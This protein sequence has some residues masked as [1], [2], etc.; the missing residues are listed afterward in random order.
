MLP[1]RLEVSGTISTAMAANVASTMWTMKVRCSGAG[2]YWASTP[3]STGPAPR[4]PI[5]ATVA[6]AGARS[7]QLGGAASM[8]AAVPV[9]VNSPADKPDS[10]R[11]TSSTGTESAPRNTA[12]LAS[13]HAV[14][15]SSIGRRPTA[16]D[17]RPNTN[18]ATSTPPA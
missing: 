6:T 13:A 9:P 5:L 7:R 14:P 2:A 10:T 4:P 1:V 3:A 11:P 16:S 15:A 17:H 8:M 18:S 12:A